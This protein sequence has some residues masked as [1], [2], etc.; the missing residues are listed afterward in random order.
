MQIAAQRGVYRPI[1]GC[2]ELDS[3]EETTNHGPGVAGTGRS[4]FA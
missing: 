1:E 4:F 3:E 2:R